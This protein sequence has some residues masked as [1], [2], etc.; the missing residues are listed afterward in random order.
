VGDSGEGLDGLRAGNTLEVDEGSRENAAR[1][2]NASR[3]HFVG[4]EAPTP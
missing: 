3:G 4:A 2:V 1:A